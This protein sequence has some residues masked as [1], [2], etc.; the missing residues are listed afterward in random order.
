MV[1]PVKG[2]INR[3]IRQGMNAGNQCI[4]NEM[5]DMHDEE[6]FLVMTSFP[7]SKQV[8]DWAIND[9]S[10]FRVNTNLCQINQMQKGN[11]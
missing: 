7:P 1:A 11:Q 5:A 3:F 2:V 6:R 8:S 10:R 4:P 9:F